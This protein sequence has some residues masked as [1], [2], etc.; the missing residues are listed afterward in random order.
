MS[1]TIPTRPDNLHLPPNLRNKVV[2]VESDVLNVCNRIRD[3]D[4][5]LYVVF[6][7]KHERPYVVMEN[8]VDG[9]ERF[10]ARYEA[11]DA[12]IIEDLQRMLRVPFDDRW[13]AEAAKVEKANREKDQEFYTSGKFDEFAH[14]L[15][16]AMIESN[17]IDGV[18]F[19]SY[20]PVKHRGR[21]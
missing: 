6:H 10:V 7:E 4:P 5:N 20:R 11:L 19:R 15:R 13:K 14:G 9:L 2:M 12:R 3:L 16:K 17:M 18:Q 8:C 1:L 21:G